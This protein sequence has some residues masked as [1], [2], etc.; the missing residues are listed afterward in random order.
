MLTIYNPKN[1][2]P[3]IVATANKLRKYFANVEIHNSYDFE[4]EQELYTNDKILDFLNTEA[5]SKAEDP[6]EIGIYRIQSESEDKWKIRFLEGC[7]VA[8]NY[9][10]NCQY[11]VL[12]HLSL[13]IV[14]ESVKITS[15][16]IQKI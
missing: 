11:T 15:T 12:S 1:S 8:T 16:M 14:M 6:Q 4:L 9:K 3:D 10:K 2:K 13:S 7:V 5:S